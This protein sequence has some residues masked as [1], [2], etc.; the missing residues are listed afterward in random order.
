MKQIEIAKNTIIYGG[1]FNP[2]TRAHHAI[3]Q[4][5]IDYAERPD[6]NA[7][8]WLLPSGDRADKTIDRTREERLR[9][10]E[11]MRQD[12]VS[13][14]VLVEIETCELDR[15][16]PVETADTVRELNEANPDRNFIWVFGAD[17]VATME[18]WKDGE[19]LKRELAML[20]IARPGTSL[21]ILG[22]NM[23]QITIPAM[24]IS[25]T[26]VRDRLK[27]HEPID[28]LVTPSVLACLV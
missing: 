25:S 20:V 15:P 27:V 26:K 4:A 8:V 19:R 14:T 24:D 3:L 5:C 1:A 23:T 18:L 7:D 22:E 6:V 28:D 12:I 10:V 16:I 11:A 2:P 21:D 17:S 9:M 13:R